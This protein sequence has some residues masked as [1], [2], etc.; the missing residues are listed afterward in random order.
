LERT[1]EGSRRGARRRG[2]RRRGQLHKEGVS[3]NKDEGNDRGY[4]GGGGGGGYDEYEYGGGYGAGGVSPQTLA[5]TRIQRLTG[6]DVREMTRGDD[7]CGM[8]REMEGEAGVTSGGERDAMDDT[9]RGG[10]G[11]GV[12][13]VQGVEE[14]EA[15]IKQRLIVGA[16]LTRRNEVDVW[17]HILTSAETMLR[18]SPTSLSEDRARL[19]RGGGGGEGSGGGRGGGRGGGGGNEGH[20][21]GA[22]NPLQLHL[23]RYQLARK[24]V[25]HRVVLQALKGLRRAYRI[26]IRA[27]RGDESRGGNRGTGSEAA[28]SG[29]WED[30]TE[31]D[32]SWDR[33]TEQWDREWEQW[34]GAL[35]DGR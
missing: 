6:A 16:P 19:Q 4:G 23:W 5:V 24:V 15:R 13:E 25:L 35:N 18:G 21:G 14:V 27:I 9:H 11:G 17:T 32:L 26:P 33:R 22:D 12:E 20:T 34:W 31:D 3:G 30:K 8:A 10:H 1:L 29:G 7:T 2:A 28:F